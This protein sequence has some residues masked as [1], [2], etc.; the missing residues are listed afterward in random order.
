MLDGLDNLRSTASR[1]IA[2]LP[3]LSTDQVTWLTDTAEQIENTGWAAEI[4]DTDWNLL[5]VSEELKVFLGSGDP[6]ELG[7]GCHI[8]E[9]HR[10]PAWRER[11]TSGTRVSSLRADLPY[12]AS[13]TPGGVDAMREMIDPELL[14]LL[15]GLSPAPAPPVWSVELELLQDRMDPVR[16]HCFS[17][18]IFDLEEKMV[19]TARIYGPGL[20]AS[21]LTMVT[22]GDEAMF[23][24]MSRLVSPGRQPVAVM[25][26]DLEASTMLSRRLPSAAYFRLISAVTKE[27]DETILRHEGLVG[28]HS[29]DGV[30][31]FF[32]GD[33]HGA[34]TSAVRASV[35]AAR[36]IQAAVPVLADQV[37]TEV[38]IQDKPEIRVNVGLHWG[39]TVYMGR[40]ATGGRLEVTA[41]GDEVNECAR[42]ESCATG[43][44]ILA[45]KALVERLSASDAGFL[46]IDVASRTYE[47]LSELVSR[48]AKADR[49]G[50]SIPVTAL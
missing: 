40:I 22:H 28:K 42:I 27:M 4:Y 38:G 25:F 8:L 33:E 50:V 49:D 43:G 9:A 6:D 47:V 24:R 41:L 13:A 17:V 39:S 10:R 48:S 23:E 46:G 34:I 30:S 14:S 12:I 21:L 15:D 16:V 19:G 2:T 37:L 29:G 3:H 44:Q 36:E 11:V 32:I 31:A 5:W 35:V 18:R 26:A 7:Y 1:A 20:R 45:S